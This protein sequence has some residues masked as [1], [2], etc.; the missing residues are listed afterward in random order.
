MF[1]EIEEKIKSEIKNLQKIIP[2][3]G[4]YQS[5]FPN[6]ASPISY[7]PK[8]PSRNSFVSGVMI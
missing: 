6:F 5:K 1:K 7:N 8:N 2:Q 4:D 3:I